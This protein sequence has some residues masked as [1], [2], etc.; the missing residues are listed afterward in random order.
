MAFKAALGR[1]A[2]QLRQERNIPDA[3]II[4]DYMTAAELDAVN[5]AKGEITA[6]LLGGTSYFGIKAVLLPL[7]IAN[8]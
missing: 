6:L 2:K 3:A 1:S 8:V 5:R 4:E 7:K